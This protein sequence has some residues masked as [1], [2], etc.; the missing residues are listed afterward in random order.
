MCAYSTVGVAVGGPKRFPKAVL[1]RLHRRLRLRREKRHPPMPAVG[2]R[3]AGHAPHFAI[4]NR[5]QRGRDPFHA[6]VHEHHGY[7][8]LLKLANLM[9]GRR[10]VVRGIQ[11]HAAHLLVEQLEH[12][13]GLPPHVVIGGAN[14]RLMV[15]IAGARLETS[16]QRR[17]EAGMG[18]QHHQGEEIQPMLQLP[19]HVRFD[20]GSLALHATNE[21]FIFQR[22]HRLADGR[23]GNTQ[24][25][26]Q[27]TLGGQGF[28]RRQPAAPH[29]INQVI[30][31]PLV[32]WTATGIV[33]KVES[34]QSVFH[35]P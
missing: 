18:F 32:F 7:P 16:Q 2:Q 15:D 28:T 3:P 17:I 11:G 24:R 10:L 8:A 5:Q 25:L 13:V 12:D 33:P 9:G 26:C 30:S 4:R 14:D 35:Q 34:E 31:Q 21:P 27:L 6:P 19:S 1:V 20:V 23:I 22:S 29:R